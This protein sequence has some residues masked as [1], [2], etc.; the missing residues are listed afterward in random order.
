MERNETEKS[1]C[2]ALTDLIAAMDKQFG[3]GT[4]MRIGDGPVDPIPVFP[5]GSLALDLAL[6]IGGIPR[7][8][9]VEVF[10][11]DCASR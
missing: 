7:G 1:R 6:G 11:P 9:M 10:G 4:L 3:K 5:S 8:R 2:K